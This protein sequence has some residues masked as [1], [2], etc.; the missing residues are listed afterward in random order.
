VISS[1]VAEDRR[2]QRSPGLSGG[3]SG[4]LRGRLEQPSLLPTTPSHHPCLNVARAN[5]ACNI[6][7]QHSWIRLLEVAECL[8]FRAANQMGFLH[9]RFHPMIAY[10]LTVPAHLCMPADLVIEMRPQ[11]LS[12]PSRT[13]SPTLNGVVSIM[14]K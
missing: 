12:E 5:F 1:K 9:N 7:R 8:G 6:L 13:I 2:M 4:D 11:I 14:S 10:F 3:L